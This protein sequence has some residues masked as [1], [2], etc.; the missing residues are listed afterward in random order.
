MRYADCRSI[1][2]AIFSNTPQQTIYISGAPGMGKTAMAYNIAEDLGMTPEQ[3]VIF[4]PSLRDPVDLMGVPAVKNN[5][6]HWNP[7]EE[8]QRMAKGRWLLVIDELPQAVTMM[9]N[10]LGGLILD[11]FVGDLKLSPDVM[12][13]A[14]GNRTID[15]AGAGRVL[16][17]VANRVM[18]LELEV[19]LDDW[20]E[21][22]LDAGIDMLTISFLR[23][24]PALLHDF[25]PDRFSNPT[26][27]SWEMVGRLPPLPQKL[28]YYAL[29]GLVGEGA[30]AEY[31]GFRRVADDM[32]DIDMIMMAPD[33]V[34]VPTDPAALYAVCGMLARKASTDSF[35]RLCTYFQRMPDE[36]QAMVVN[37]AVHREPAIKHTE[38]F[39]RWAVANAK[40]FV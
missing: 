24:R 1:C 38:A 28:M 20:C 14:T 29:S 40:V 35:G 27:R 5:Q 15:K 2:T 21:W 37:D 39:I 26:P 31:E 32:P 22:A 25:L 9:Q 30:A 17:Q 16:S 13:M 8:L 33:K 19:H 36:F 3:V 6:T 4:R 23:F 12:I 7:P 11:R 10:A 18:H 34:E